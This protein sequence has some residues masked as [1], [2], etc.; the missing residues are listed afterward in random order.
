MRTEPM[1]FSTLFRRRPAYLET[2]SMLLDGAVAQSRRPEFY[3]DG[4]V[5]DT[6]DGRFDLLVLHVF[7]VLQRLQSIADA[8][9]LAQAV[10]DR[11]FRVLDL[12]LREMGVQ[13]MGIG[14]RIKVMA[15]GYNGRALAFRDALEADGDELRTTLRRNVFGG[16]AP[17]EAQAAR[18]TSYVRCTARRLAAHTDAEITQGRLDFPAP[19]D[20]AEEPDR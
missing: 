20:C 15:E 10:L 4:G 7:L 2:A 18:M 11:M 8:G 1:S 13:D 12:N 19:G 14:K 3:R 6:L 9:P 5:P 16:V 17:S